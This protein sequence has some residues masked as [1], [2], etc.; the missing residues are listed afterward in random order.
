MPYRTHDDRIDGVVI[1]FSDITVAKALETQLRETQARLE[2]RLA[3]QSASQAEAGLPTTPGAT[4]GEKNRN[5][6]K[7]R[8]SLK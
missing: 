8:R 5:G 4:N 7:A 2:K 3:E 1:T 6:A